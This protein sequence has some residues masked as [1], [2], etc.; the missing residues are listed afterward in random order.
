MHSKE[1]NE[2]LT[3]RNEISN[4]WLDKMLFQVFDG[5]IS[6][7]GQAQTLQGAPRLPPF[8]QFGAWGSRFLTASSA[9]M[10]SAVVFPP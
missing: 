10:G 6:L 5:F 8:Q 3:T 9:P 1:K 7:S 2:Q 4:V